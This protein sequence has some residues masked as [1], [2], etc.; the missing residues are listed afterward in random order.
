MAEDPGKAVLHFKE[1]YETSILCGEQSRY[2]S[3]ECFYSPRY[4]LSSSVLFAQRRIPLFVC[5][6]SP[7]V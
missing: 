5:F 4:P 6:L 1:T 3:F 2:Y 7:A